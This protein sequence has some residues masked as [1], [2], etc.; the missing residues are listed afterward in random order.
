MVRHWSRTAAH[1]AVLAALL[2]TAGCGGG[3]RIG[4]DDVTDDDLSAGTDVPVQADLQ[5]QIETEG[6]A[7]A[8]AE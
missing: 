7:E 6:E 4:V 8:A 2:L 3:L 5:N 1:V